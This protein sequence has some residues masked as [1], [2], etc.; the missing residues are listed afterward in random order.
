[1]CVVIS[2]WV[3]LGNKC[4][5]PQLRWGGSQPIITAA[6]YECHGQLRRCKIGLQLSRRQGHLMMA[7]TR[8]QTAVARPS[9]ILPFFFFLETSGA[10]P[11]VHWNMS[12]ATLAIFPNFFLEEKIFYPQ[13]EWNVVVFSFGLCGHFHF[14]HVGLEYTCGV[15]ALNSLCECVCVCWEGRGAFSRRSKADKPEVETSIQSILKKC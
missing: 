9:Q 4:L 8:P 14:L 6:H 7:H 10:P 15:W 2:E 5:W 3:E 12:A 11:C 13:F 1:M